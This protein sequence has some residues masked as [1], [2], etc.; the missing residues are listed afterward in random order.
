LMNL[1]ARKWNFHPNV[2]HWVLVGSTV[3]QNN[4]ML[5]VYPTCRKIRLIEVNAKCRNIKNLPLCKGTLRQVF[6]GVCRLHG[7]TVHSVM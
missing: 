1:D 5:I 2:F 4:W 3:F 7:D 6:N